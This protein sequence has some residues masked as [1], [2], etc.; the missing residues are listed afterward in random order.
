[1]TRKEFE[2]RT[3]L[4]VTMADYSFIE[5]V[6]M[7]AGNLDKDAFCKDWKQHGE[8]LLVR[9]LW[10]RVRDLVNMVKAQSD[11]NTSQAQETNELLDFMLERAQK[12]GDVELLKK[13][14]EFRG[15]AYVICRKLELGL[16]LWELDKDYIKKNIK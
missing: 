10:Y 11:V 4:S 2:D 5:E 13:A 14:I 7:A 8:S 9:E 6:Y 1:M 3:G 16:P 15:N 12:F